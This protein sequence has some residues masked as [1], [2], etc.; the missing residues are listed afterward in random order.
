M[1][2]TN[3]TL[4]LQRIEELMSANNL[5]TKEILTVNEAAEYLDL[6]PAY[7]YHLTSKRMIPFCRPGRKLYFQKADLVSWIQNS[8]QS[9][10]DE[11]F[12]K[13][14]LNSKQHGK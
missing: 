8:R 3:L 13:N 5:A 9:T 1:L 6:K 11:L 14:P 10:V 12:S 2:R 4:Q 7:I